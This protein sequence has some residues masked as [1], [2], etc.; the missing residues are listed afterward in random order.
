MNALLVSIL[1]NSALAGS[2]DDTLKTVDEALV[3]ATD[4]SSVMLAHTEVPGSSPKETSFKLMV[5]G[6]QRFVD[7]LGPAD[8]KGTRVLVASPTQMFVWLPAYNKVRRVA[9]HVKSQG[10]MGTMFS[11]A[12]MSTSQFTV[13]YQADKL[14]ETAELTTLKLTPKPDAKTA[15]AAIEMDVL[16]SNNLPAALRY[17]DD[18]GQHVKTETRTDY[19]CGETPKGT[20]CTPGLFK[21]VDHTRKDAFTTL[22]QTEVVINGGVADDVFSQRTLQRG[23]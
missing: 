2:A 6:E 22:T 15:Y 1:V 5:K 20:Y 16:K 7:F 11:D 8:M 21:M 9:S 13:F 3:R 12:D 19:Q 17:F 23:L 4:T 14:T 10:F 18:S